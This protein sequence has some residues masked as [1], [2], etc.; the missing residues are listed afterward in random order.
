MG[1]KG[2]RPSWVSKAHLHRSA[3]L[4]L[5]R[6]NPKA[7]FIQS[8]RGDHPAFYEAVIGGSNPIKPAP[9]HVGMTSSLCQQVHFTLDEFRFWSRAIAHAPRFHRKLW[10]WFFIIQT[11][12]EAGM[13]AAGRKGLVFAV[14]TEPLPAL[15]AS[16]GCEIL[17]TDQSREHASAQGWIDTHQHASELLALSRPQIC[18][19][20]LF[21]ER[22]SFRA[23]DMNDLP[24]DLNGQFD[25]CW[26]ACS[27]EHL[28]SLERGIEFVENA[29][30]TLKSGGIAVHTT[31]FNLS[32]NDATMETAALSIFRRRDIET[33]V[34]RLTRAGHRVSP[35]N[36]NQGQGFIEDFVDLPPYSA[37]SHLRL[38]LGKFDCTSIGLVVRRGHTA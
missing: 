22:V 11:V 30:Q 9:G 19:D 37:S 34:D 20:A 3:E 36:W 12:F 17:A 38:A 16:Y 31:E 14:G 15:F 33:L 32:S 10:E 2:F 27:F 4:F 7:R 8:F 21:R 24:A 13:M 28:G 18:D 29:M 25:F 26:S 1:F 6:F 35:V 5:R 23:V